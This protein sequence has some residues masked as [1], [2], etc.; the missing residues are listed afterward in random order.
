MP[1]FDFGSD[2][3][4]GAYSAPTDPLAGGEGASRPLP[5]NHTAASAFGLDFRPFGPLTS[6][7]LAPRCP[8]PKYHYSPQHWGGYEY[9]LGTTDRQTDRRASHP[10]YDNVNAEHGRCRA[11]VIRATRSVH[12]ASTGLPAVD[13]IIRRAATT[14]RD[15]SA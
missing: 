1:K 3:A 6:A 5:K 10:L 9:T 4:G 11:G 15:A 14:S 8:P 13:W 2:P 12:P 7:P